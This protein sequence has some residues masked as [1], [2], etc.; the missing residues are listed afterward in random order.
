MKTLIEKIESA[1]QDIISGYST[2]YIKYTDEN[3][4]SWTIRISNHMANPSRVTDN[5]I[6]LVV[7][8][9]SN[10]NTEDNWS[11]NEKSFRPIPN[12]FFLDETGD[13]TDNFEN[14]EDMLNY[15]IE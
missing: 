5:F 9:P 1:I 12:Q 15:V 10:I 3:D 14:I 7:D 6:S 13:F 4:N 8:V 2:Q 11:I